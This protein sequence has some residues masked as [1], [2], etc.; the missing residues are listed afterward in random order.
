MV[1]KM[2]LRSADVEIVGECENGYEAITAIKKSR[3]DLVFLDVQM[4]EMDGF[5]VIDAIKEEQLPHI[6]FVTAYDQYAVRAFDV[7][8]LDYLLKPFDEERFAEALERAKRQIRR[9][10]ES[11][12]W[13]GRILALLAEGQASAL[14]LERLIIKTGGRVFFLKTE[15]VKWIEAEGNYV[16]LHTG[17]KKYL[18]REAISSLAAQLDPRKF[19]RI[20]RSTIVNIEYI[21]ELQP[22]FRG[23]YKVIL[24]D[25]TELKLSH[26]YRENLTKYLGGSL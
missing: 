23:D 10:D 25:G 22:W 18:F 8:A 15:E 24:H 7:H 2:L 21:R 19:Q 1:R 6:I 4:P 11:T 13:R 16:A 14:Y 12:D 3:P 17:K 20:Q 26:R 5:G 9:G